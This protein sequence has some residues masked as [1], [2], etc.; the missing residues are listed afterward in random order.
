MNL[1][2]IEYNK[3]PRL[4]EHCGNSI[5]FT[6]R[7][8]K[9][10]SRACAG[11]LSNLNRPKESE[12]TKAKRKISNSI[13]SKKQFFHEFK[14]EKYVT[15]DKKEGVLFTKV[16]QCKV[17]GKYFPGWHIRKTCSIE[18]RTTIFSE[19]GKRVSSKLMNRSK[20]EIALFELCK[21]HFSNVEHN[22]RLFN[23]W[24]ADV[25]IH[26]LKIAIL[27]NGPWHYK[28]MNFSNHSLIKV[29]NRDALKI[30]EI[31]KLGWTPIIYED[32]LFNPDTAFSHLLNFISSRCENA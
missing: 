17:C 7:F 5:S 3:N 2:E 8:N 15:W 26:D 30:E 13:S 22:V 14:N 25:I 21:N 27:W 9:C 23:G 32:R 24:D 1:K 16:A 6:K 31:K 4:C 12:V 20:D 18:C 19:T 29:Q 11:V 10:C 28:Q